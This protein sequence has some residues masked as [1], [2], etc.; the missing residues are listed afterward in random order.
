[1]NLVNFFEENTHGLLV[2]FNTGT[3][4]QVMK[5]MTAQALEPPGFKAFPQQKHRLATIIMA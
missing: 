3:N 1:M 5:R 4:Q 2:C